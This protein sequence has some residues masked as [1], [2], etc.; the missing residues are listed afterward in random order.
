M[1]IVQQVGSTFISHR[2]NDLND[3]ISFIEK[4][5]AILGD[6]YITDDDSFFNIKYS[7]LKNKK[8]VSISRSFFNK[9]PKIFSFVFDKFN[10]IY[11]IINDDIDKK[12]NVNLK[13]YFFAHDYYKEKQEYINSK[14]YIDS[15]FE[16]FKFILI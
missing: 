14:R 5:N 12:T 15:F 7:K 6:C 13:T 9:Y 10:Y 2:A 8:I 16:F 1:F 3:A 4:N 11:I